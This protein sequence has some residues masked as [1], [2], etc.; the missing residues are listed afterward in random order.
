VDVVGRVGEQGYAGFDDR[1]GGLR[2]VV[3]R[4]PWRPRF[5]RPVG[6]ALG[7]LA[8]LGKQ[9]GDNVDRMRNRGTPQMREA[10]A[11]GLQAG[12][13]LLLVAAGVCVLPAVVELALLLLAWPFWLVALR[14]PWAPRTVEVRRGRRVVH[15][16]RVRD[17]DRATALCAQLR[18]RVAAGEPLDPEPTDF[19]DL[20]VRPRPRR[21]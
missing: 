13:L 1:A 8:M 9:T 15:S 4:L 12:L 2:V 21:W 6:E 11:D 10:R 16:E 17:A 20:L 18:E 3:L 14:L 5:L 19:S 7:E